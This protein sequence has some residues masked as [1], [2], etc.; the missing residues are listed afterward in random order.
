MRFRV[1][2]TH[3]PAHIALALAVAGTIACAKDALPTYVPHDSSLRALPVYCYPAADTTRPPRALVFFYGNDLGFWQPHR[4]LAARL[5]RAN[6]TVAG[7]DPRTLL[8]TLPSEPRVRDSAFAASAVAL[9]RAV[10]RELHAEHVPLIIAGH[11]L[12]AEIALWTAAYA[13]PAGTVGVLAMSPGG[14]SHLTITAADL[15][16][17]DPDPGPGTFVVADALH[18][19]PADERVAVVR[20][21]RDRFR[22]ADSGLAV[23]GGARYAHYTVPLANH[24]LKALLLAG[25]IVEWALDWIL[26]G[27]TSAAGRPDTSPITS[28]STRASA[29]PPG[30]A[31]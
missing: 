8:A 5:A 28:A 24:S 16:S 18:A 14:R 15:L 13:R 7:V 11:S 26:A 6:Y 2:P 27:R 20:G 17:R 30:A 1:I 19:I 12:G 31:R 3:R 21:S 25:P 29:I 10:Q 22:S 23:A 4:T 9:I